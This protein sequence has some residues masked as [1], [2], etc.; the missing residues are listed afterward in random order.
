MG[1]RN[2]LRQK[3]YRLA[4]TCSSGAEAYVDSMFYNEVLFV[5][6]PWQIVDTAH[7]NILS[8]LFVILKVI[9]ILI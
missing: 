5:K 2:F 3:S 7:V 8:P 4:A 1:D 9:S 6:K